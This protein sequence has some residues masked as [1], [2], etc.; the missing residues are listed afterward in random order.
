MAIPAGLI[1]LVGLG[2]VPLNPALTML[3]SAE[4]TLRFFVAEQAVASRLVVFE[5]VA[6]A[7]D[8]SREARAECGGDG[9]CGGCACLGRV[10]DCAL[11]N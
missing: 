7:E 1:D 6:N 4:S 5:G 8:A 11:R 9:L 10:S 2:T 3:L